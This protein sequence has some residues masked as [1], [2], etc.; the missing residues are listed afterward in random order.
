MQFVI[1]PHTSIARGYRRAAE[2]AA[3]I[4]ANTFQ[5]FTR[6]PRG[7]NAKAWRNNYGT[8]SCF[9]ELNQ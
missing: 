3:A 9:K 7:G 6:N 1:G 8:A 2:E 4:R 5:F